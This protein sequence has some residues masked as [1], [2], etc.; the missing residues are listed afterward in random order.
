MAWFVNFPVTLITFPVPLNI[1]ISAPTIAMASD[2]L[3]LIMFPALTLP[4][5]IMLG[6]FFAELIIF[7]GF[8]RMSVIFLGAFGRNLIIFLNAIAVLTPICDAA[9]AAN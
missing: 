7:L 6:T 9:S 4:L 8:F 2:G 1:K 3:V 5:F